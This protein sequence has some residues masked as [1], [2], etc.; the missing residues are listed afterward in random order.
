MRGKEEMYGP[1]HRRG[2]V[3]A[4]EPLVHRSGGAGEGVEGDDEGGGEEYGYHQIGEGARRHILRGMVASRGG[5]LLLGPLRRWRR[6]RRRL[7]PPSK[8]A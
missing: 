2:L 7:R 6:R 8:L 4:V 5:G 1:E 3:P